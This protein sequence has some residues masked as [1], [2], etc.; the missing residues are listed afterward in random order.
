MRLESPRGY[1]SP[2]LRNCR[3]SATA[4]KNLKWNSTVLTCLG[5]VPRAAPL[6]KANIRKS[7]ALENAPRSGPNSV[8]PKST[9]V[10]IAIRRGHVI[11]AH[12]IQIIVQMKFR[13]VLQF[14]AFED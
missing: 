4:Q 11:A 9:H 10:G 5:E 13:Q 3:V 1:H 2:P 8:R 14:E 7:D 6:E 12:R